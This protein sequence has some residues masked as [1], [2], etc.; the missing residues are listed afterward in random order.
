MRQPGKLIEV[1]LKTINVHNIPFLAY[2]YS[3]SGKLKDL[4]IKVYYIFAGTVFIIK[5]LGF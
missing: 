4:H 1:D 2:E 5:V 3:T